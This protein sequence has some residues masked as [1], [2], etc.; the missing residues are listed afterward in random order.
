MHAHTQARKE[1]HKRKKNAEVSE[2]NEG[3][4]EVKG[5]TLI[6]LCSTDFSQI[7]WSYAPIWKTKGKKKNKYMRSLNIRTSQW[8]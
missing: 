1:V 3:N 5:F 2:N 7:C 4:K 6:S 8:Q